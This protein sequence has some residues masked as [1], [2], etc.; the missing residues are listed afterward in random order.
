[1]LQLLVL[2]SV[3][4]KCIELFTS[5]GSPSPAL[6]SQRSRLFSPTTHTQSDS[7]SRR[8]LML[9]RY[10]IFHIRPFSFSFMPLSSSLSLSRSLATNLPLHFTST[11]SDVSEI[12]RSSTHANLHPS[13]HHTY[14]ICIQN[15]STMIVIYNNF[16]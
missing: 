6:L 10:H 9:S 13:I 14:S 8:T 4:Y 16:D 7:L 5:V 11:L 15:L 1:M 2:L 3:L 12:W